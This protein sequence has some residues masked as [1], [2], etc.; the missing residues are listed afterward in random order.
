MTSIKLNS[1]AMCLVAT[2][3]AL[4]PEHVGASTRALTEYDL[5]QLM[6]VDLVVTSAAKRAQTVDD[7]AAAVH[8]LTSEDIRR[9]GASSIP[10]LLRTVP[11]VQVARIN[12]RSWAVTARGFNSQFANKLQVLVDGRSIYA[13]VFS[14]V[15]WEEQFIPLDQIERIE[16]VRGPGGALWGINAVNG[17]INII[18]KRASEQ[19]GLRLGASSGA[20]TSAS[21]ALQAANGLGSMNLWSQAGRAD[22]L[23]SD[24]NELDRS[25]FGAQFERTSDV[26]HFT[27]RTEYASYDYGDDS[28]LAD[29]V[30]PVSADV[31]SAA[32]AWR[33]EHA[34]LRQTEVAAHYGEADRGEGGKEATIGLDVQHTYPRRGRHLL[35]VGAAHRRIADDQ[36]D[37]A[38]LSNFSPGDAE[39]EQWSVY[40]Q[41]E[42]FTAADRARLIAGAKLEH[43]EYTGLSFQPTLRAL[44]HASE[45]HTFWSAASRAERTPSRFELHSDLVL[46]VASPGLPTIFEIHGNRAL[47]TET[48]D[49]LEAGW[50]WRMSVMSFDLSVFTNNY[51]DLI[52]YQ[53]SNPRIEWTPAPVLIVP[54]Q[55]V[56]AG[57]AR[58]N[59]AELAVELLASPQ[60]RLRGTAHL[61]DMDVPA[62]E[63][64]T[65]AFGSDPRFAWSLQGRYD[66]SPAVELDV[67]LRTMAQSEK[68]YT[69]RYTS[70]DARLAWRTAAL[71]LSLSATNILNDRHVEFFDEASGLPG[72]QIGRAVFARLE[73][74]GQ[75]SP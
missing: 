75:S 7:A 39:Y 41:D 4:L 6:S 45:A 38:G 36:R 31:A 16:V 66:Y 72:V 15:L 73:W 21:I 43:F 60:L 48:V 64:T 17:V 44:W 63:G 10:D 30:L 47:T 55:Y 69:A 12:T 51:K 5:Q 2:L 32:L 24:I 59:G 37:P 42:I 62:F 18:T 1:A 35:T 74:S 13:S 54:L 3:S 40:A 56:N 11:G 50:R 23:R 28:K 68:I 70:L 19:E 58:A 71:T 9:S 27:F 33:H 61:F 46:P 25:T 26:D 53:P 65:N 20:D 49:A 29:A 52:V 57:D 34:D 8:V 67:S 22:P 14:G